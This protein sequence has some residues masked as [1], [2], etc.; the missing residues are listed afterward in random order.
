MSQGKGQKM[1]LCLASVCSAASLSVYALQM[2]FQFAK[3]FLKTQIGRTACILVSIQMNPSDVASG[4]QS[5]IGVKKLYRFCLLHPPQ[6][7]F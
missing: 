1:L 7:V 6:H 3:V 2:H 4:E 5:L